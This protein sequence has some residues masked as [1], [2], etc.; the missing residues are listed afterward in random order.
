VTRA[1]SQEVRISVGGDELRGALLLPNNVRGIV[2]VALRSTKTERARVLVQELRERG[3]GTLLMPLFTS[4]EEAHDSETAELRFNV[5]LLGRRILMQISA[6]E[7][8]VSPRLA[9][10]VLASS[11]AAAGALVAAA[12]RPDIIRAL[13]LQGGRPELAVFALRD[14]RAAT[15]LLVGSSDEL[16]IHSNQIAS[17]RLHALHQLEIVEGAGHRFE[18][19]GKLHEIATVTAQ[20]FGRHLVQLPTKPP[21]PG[22]STSFGE[23]VRDEM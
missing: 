18:E 22:V 2:L 10:G 19:P 4:D 14:V 3:I 17:S 11:T 9:F 13:V 20:W 6:V 16:C 5:R 21:V 12:H 1:S 7:A 15:L 8:L 23:K